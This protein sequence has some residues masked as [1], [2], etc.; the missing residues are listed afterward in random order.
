MEPESC[1]RSRLEIRLTLPGTL[2]AWA[3]CMGYRRDTPTSGRGWSPSPRLVLVLIALAVL[4][5]LRGRLS[6]FHPNFRSVRA[7]A[8]HGGV[9]GPCE[10]GCTL[11]GWCSSNLEWRGPWGTTIVLE[12]R[13]H[14]Q[15]EPVRWS[16]R[17]GMLEVTRGVERRERSKSLLYYTTKTWRS[18]YEAP[19]QKIEVAEL[20]RTAWRRYPG[21]VVPEPH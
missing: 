16:L 7:Q 11:D 20:D 9:V 15:C 14:Q 3:T 18:P 2:V 8:W 21:S 10:H 4:F 6:I 12:S 5:A 17:G 13:P 19:T 1:S